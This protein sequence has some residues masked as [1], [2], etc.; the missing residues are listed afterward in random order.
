MRAANGP[1][2]PLPHARRQRSCV[3]M[4][5]RSQLPIKVFSC[6]PLHIVHHPLRPVSFWDT[7][8]AFEASYLAYTVAATPPW[9][10]CTLHYSSGTISDH[11]KEEKGETAASGASRNTKKLCAMRPSGQYSRKSP[12]SRCQQLNG[13]STA[14]ADCCNCSS[15]FSTP[16]H[17]A[18]LIRSR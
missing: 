2:R 16:Q 5:V 4:L 7:L 14:A 6:R 1:S 18:W 3:L 10:L 8:N 12:S 15:S 13:L 11:G 17:K 9:T